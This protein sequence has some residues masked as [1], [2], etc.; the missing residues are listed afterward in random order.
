M[1]HAR[2]GFA[3]VRHAGLVAFGVVGAVLWWQPSRAEALLS[4]ADR[5]EVARSMHALSKRMDRPRDAAIERGAPVESRPDSVLDVVGRVVYPDGSPASGATV[6]AGR[7]RPVMAGVDGA[8]KASLLEMPD[9]GMIEVRAFGRVD[10]ERFRARIDFSL[11]ASPAW[12]IDRLDV[13]PIVLESVNTCTGI[14]GWQQGIGDPGMGESGYRSIFGMAVFDDGNGPALYAGGQF[15]SAGGVAASNIARWDGEQWSP[16]GSGVNGSVSCLAV[17]DDGSGPALY[18]GGSFTMAGG[19][20]ANRIARWDGSVWSSVGVG[21]DQGSVWTLAVLD[22]GLSSALFAGGTFTT[23]GGTSVNHLARWNGVAWSSVGGGVD[24]FVSELIVHNDGSG[25]SLFAGGRFLNAGGV[26]ANRVARWNG[27]SWSPLGAGMNNWVETFA[28]WDDGSGSALYAG[29]LFTTAGGSTANRVARW[30]GSSWSA[31]GSGMNDAVYALTSFET[32][33]GSMLVAGGKFTTADGSAASRV[34]SFDG[35]AWWSLEDG[36][37]TSEVWIMAT[38]VPSGSSVEELVLGGTFTAAGGGVAD[39][40]AAWGCV[41]E[42]A[43]VLDDSN[44]SGILWFEFPSPGGTASINLPVT[45][46]DCEW[47]TYDYGDFGY[48][49]LDFDPAVGLGEV[50]LELTAFGGGLC[51]QPIDGVI[52]L[53]DPILERSADHVILWG[54]VDADECG[55]AGGEPLPPGEMVPAIGWSQ[56]D[57]WQ[58]NATAVVW[59]NR[60]APDCEA[61]LSVSSN[62]PWASVSWWSWQESCTCDFGEFPWCDQTNVE[63]LVDPNPSFEP[64]TATI[65]YSGDYSHSFTLTQAGSPDCDGNGIPDT[66]E[67]LEGSQTDCNGNGILDLCES[68]L[69]RH[70]P[71]DH[72]TIQ[73]AIDAAPWCGV[74]IVAPGYYPEQLNLGSKRVSVVSSHGPEVTIIDATGLAGPAVRIGSEASSWNEGRLDGFTIRGGSS[75]API[76]GVTGLSGGG[77]VLILNGRSGGTY[78]SYSTTLRDCIIE[79][80]AA[81]SGGGLFV[82]KGSPHLVDVIVVENQAT[83]DGGGAMVYESS[84]TF[85]RCVFEANS[86]GNK[87]GGL[88]AVRGAPNVIDGEFIENVAYGSGGGLGWFAGTSPFEVDGALFQSSVAAVAGNATWSSP[89]ASNLELARVAVCGSGLSPFSGG[90]TANGPLVIDAACEDC[91]SNGIPDTW[92]VLLMPDLDSNGDGEID[93]CICPG[94]LDGDGFVGG[95]DLTSL[96][97]AWGEPGP[98]DLDGNGLVDGGDL[99]FLLILWGACPPG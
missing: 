29:G 16:L 66:A 32:T 26:A 77:G 48:A 33:D 21:M 93:A 84:V 55:G 81:G 59:W 74:V 89:G 24:G 10:G 46:P 53:W 44:K 50:G 86:A 54:F 25:T 75:G 1:I 11:G 98:A 43:F 15:A 51:Y 94:D 14:Y 6:V 37:N 56:V 63:F 90:Y 71:G 40:V 2:T 91:N 7:G 73:A 17:F 9:D 92:E 34:A 97:Q 67:L 68:A 87:G 4:S 58:E 18:V 95:S 39:R 64:R 8:F 79:G 30:D 3:G 78:D 72:S 12:T 20:P 5:T 52:D 82:F 85:E 35:G 83:S 65:T 41:P 13:P 57:V 28:I 60:S 42:C 99:G 96:F 45:R 70:V 36:V 69:V 23:I 80:N 49:W 88:Y 22:D 47:S 62:Q 38:W 61:T 19:V 27:S 31:V 76:P